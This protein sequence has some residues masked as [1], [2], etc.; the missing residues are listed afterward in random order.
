MRKQYSIVIVL[1]L[2]L[3]AAC[4]R[5]VARVGN[6]PVYEK[7]LELRAK[8]SAVYY[9]ESGKRHVALAQ[10]VNGYLSL[11][12][13]ESLGHRVDSTV[14]EAEARRIDENT[15]AADVLKKV[16]DVYGRD[17]SA[18]LGTFVRIVYAERMLYEVFSGSEDIHRDE[19]RTAEEFLHK[20]VASPGSFSALGKEKGIKIVTLRLSA[21]KGIRP[22]KE[23]KQKTSPA[24]IEQARR[25]IAA[26]SNTRP[27]KVCPEIIEWQEGYQV[28]RLSGREKGDIVLDSASIPKKDFNTWFWSKAS[29]IP[30]LISDAHLKD[31]L[32]REVSWA[33][34]LKTLSRQPGQ[35]GF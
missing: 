30:V 2:L 6:V 33:K 3:F 13:L 5:E 11:I 17:K 12:V 15:K 27:G 14:L 32:L 19:H 4:S 25:V 16:K 9:P 24:G 8:V 1:C 26:V 35:S 28:V 20:A 29:G 34:N 10:L 18:Y 22:Y 31:E 7:D 23:K 21:E